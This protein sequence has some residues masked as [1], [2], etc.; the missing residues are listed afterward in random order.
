MKIYC[1]YLV[2]NHISPS[3]YKAVIQDE[4]INIG[5]NECVLYAYTPEKSSELY[6]LATRNMEIFFEKVI[7]ISREEYEEYFYEDHKDQVLEFNSF[8]SKK[9]VDGK[10]KTYSTQLLCT[11]AEADMII[12][13]KEDLVMDC[14][15]EILNDD[16]LEYLSCHPFHESLTKVLDDYFMYTDIMSKVQPMEDINYDNFIVDDLS[17]YIKL[18]ANTF[19]KRW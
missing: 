7:D 2:K 3:K 12:Y 4:I 15:S 5:G 14:I 16:I 1:F 17:L 10:Y 11:R 6:F 13:Y 19:K 9:L 18:F 8:N